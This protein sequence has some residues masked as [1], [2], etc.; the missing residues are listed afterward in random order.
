MPNLPNI[1]V[2]FSPELILTLG[3]LVVLAYDVAVRGREAAQARLALGTLVLAIGATLWL[4]TQGPSAIFETRGV[5]DGAVV[6]PGT[7]VSDGFTHFFRL[8][9]LVTTLLVTLSGLA[10]MRGRTPF[11]GEF[12]A[13][14][15]SAALAMNLMAG[16]NDLILV[17][18]AI[19]FL[20]LTS[21]V[22]TAYLRDDP[23]SIEGGL[24]YFLYGSITSA[25]MLFG[26][27]FLYGAAGTTVLADPTGMAPASL[28]IA[29]VT[30]DSAHVMT[31]GLSSVLL[32]GLL[33][34]MAGI[35]FK[36]ALVPYHQWSP[37][38]Y[39]GAPTPITAFLSVGPKAA[40]FAV[41][42]RLMLSAFGEPAL[43]ASWMGG[44]AALAVLTMVLGNVAALTQDNVKRM[45]AYSSIAQAGYMM[46]GLVA[47]GGGKLAGVDPVGAVLVYIL[48]YVFTNLGAFAVIVA[49]D[50]ATGSSDIE[51]FGGLM[52][53]APILAVALAVF[54]LSLVGIPPLGGFIGKFA[55]FGAAVA[56]GQVGLALIGV[57][58]GVV[59]VGYYFRVMKV[60]FFAPAPEGASPIRPAPGLMLVIPV[61]LVMTLVIGLWPGPFLDLANQAARVIAPLAEAVATE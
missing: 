9:G 28:T 29:K 21:Y 48:A 35:G 14:V 36:I 22:L 45:M 61:A 33:L 60:A 51:A 49:V 23:L 27:T 12:Y 59:S 53:R 19:E 54:F 3:I 1:L 15:L 56:G 39:Q 13:L 25:A 16:A 10:Y 46:I 31:A 34:V 4:S 24:K 7:F 52:H 43:A 11:K 40:G 42:L 17:A 57:L 50:D 55:V 18:L 44:L 47:M 2:H 8:I 37:D 6:R 38:A 26:M 32:P 5:V 41:L 20:S 58:T 30:G